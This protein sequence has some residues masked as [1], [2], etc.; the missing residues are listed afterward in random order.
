MGFG[1]R[2]KRIRHELAE[3]QRFRCCYCQRRFGAK[4]TPL[5]PT[6]EHLKARM[7][8]GTNARDNLAAACRHCNQHRG[9]QKNSAR[10]EAQARAAAARTGT[11][12]SLAHPTSTEPV[13]PITSH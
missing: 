7:D 8:G 5:A 13:L 9:S 10:Q 4:G 6:I 2:G 12:A 3:A 11:L 1:N